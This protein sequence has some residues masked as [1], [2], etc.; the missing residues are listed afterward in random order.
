MDLDFSLQPGLP[1]LKPNHKVLSRD[2]QMRWSPPVPTS[3]YPGWSPFPLGPTSSFSL[4]I[5]DERCRCSLGSKDPCQVLVFPL[6]PSSP[7][8][9][10]GAAA[11][12]LPRGLFT[13]LLTSSAK[14]LFLLCRSNNNRV[15]INN[16]RLH[17]P[18][19]FYIYIHR[20]VRT[21]PDNQISPRLVSWNFIFDNIYI[22]PNLFAVLDL[23]LK[24]LF[25]F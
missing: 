19:S 16:H 14:S 3:L 15:I 9:G 20:C 12:L 1:S 2:S 23:L 24:R 22:V 10:L 11:L 6:P 7:G 4:A 21:S 8:G 18:G 5:G 17:F 25:F 13:D